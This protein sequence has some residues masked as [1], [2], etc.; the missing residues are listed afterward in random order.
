MYSHESAGLS[1]FGE[2]TLGEAGPEW[3]TYAP[4]RS[5]CWGFPT[6]WISRDLVVLWLPLVSNSL[7]LLVHRRVFVR[8]CSGGILH[9]TEPLQGYCSYC[10]GHHLITPYAGQSWWWAVLQKLMIGGRDCSHQ[11]DPWPPDDGIVGRFDV[12]DAEFHDD[13]V[14]ICSDGELDFS[15]RKGFTPVE[16][17]EKRQGLRD[18]HFSGQLGSVL[19]SI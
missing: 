10:S 14:W 8:T 1:W 4:S 11:V 6:W 7:L 19:H 15:E 12:E 17:I 5:C 9:P 3:I 2:P 18:D 13:V 16:S